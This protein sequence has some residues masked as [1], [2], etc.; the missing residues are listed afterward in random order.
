MQIVSDCASSFLEGVTAKRPT[1]QSSDIP[2]HTRRMHE[3]AVV[4][5]QGGSRKQVQSG[6]GAAPLKAVTI[7]GSNSADAK[8]VQDSPSGRLTSPRDWHGWEN[9]CEG[10][11]A[12]RS[13]RR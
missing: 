7:T 3:T 2:S 9:P 10:I 6:A 5:Q 11:A 13:K 4:E 8:L 12:H 1:A